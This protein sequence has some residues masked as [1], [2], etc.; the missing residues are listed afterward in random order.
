LN[1]D[2]FIVSFFLALVTLH[3]LSRSD[4]YTSVFFNSFTPAAKRNC[5][6]KAANSAISPWLLKMQMHYNTATAW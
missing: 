6:A 1:F 5:I 2:H 4:L 3:L